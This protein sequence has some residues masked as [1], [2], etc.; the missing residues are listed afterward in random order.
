MPPFVTRR[1]FVPSVEQ[2]TSIEQIAI[3]DQAPTTPA[4]GVGT[5]AI[6]CVGEYEDGPFAMPREVFGEDDLAS[7]FGGF[8]YTYGSLVHQNPS[9]RRRAQELWNGNA[10][11]KLK[12]LRPRRLMVTRVDTSVGNLIGGLRATVRSAPGP[13]R[14]DTTDQLDVSFD[15]GGAVSLP[16]LAAGVA[17]LN[18]SGASFP[19]ALAGQI[20]GVRID[21]GAEVN[22]QLPIGSTSLADVITTFNNALGYTAASDN[23]G[24]LRISGIQQGTGGR[25]VLRQVFGNSLVALGFTID[26]AGESSASG[27]GDVADI[28][29]VTATEA[30]AAWS[31]TILGAGGISV[32]TDDGRLAIGS[33]T[34]I[35]VSAGNFQ[36]VMGFGTDQATRAAQT[37]FSIPAGTRVTA[38]SIDFVT[39]QTVN[40]PVGGGTDALIL[41]V[42]HAFDDGSG[43]AVA[44]NTTATFVDQPLQ[45]LLGAVDANGLTAALTE[46]QMDARYEAAFDSTLD[47]NSVARDANFTLSARRTAA[48]MRAGRSNAIR[49]SENGLRGRVFHGRASFGISPSDAITDVNLYRSDRVFYTYPGWQSQISEI[50]T[51]GNTGGLGFNDS[52]T[53][54]IGG[55][56]P[57]AYINSV[58]NPEENPGQQTG[59]LTFVQ[60]LEPIPSFQAATTSLEGPIALY[61]Q[62]KSAGI[63]APRFGRDGQAAYQS[64]VTTSLEPGRTTQKRRKMADFIQDSLA[65]LMIPF[66]K[67]LATDAREA[68]ITATINS[69]LVILL[70]DNFPENQRIA[71]FGV[72]N[73]NASNPDYGRLGISARKVQVQILNSLD[74]ILLVTEIGEG[75]V[76]V[77]DAAAAA[78]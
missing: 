30:N 78:A 14:L 39:M 16:V 3:V 46:P 34:T 63:C 12:N 70:S 35:Q 47:I 21:N 1:T 51:V 31:G 37:A 64:E 41:P 76:V 22:V 11:L 45:I 73:I 33:T 8:G 49:A 36:Q 53:I 44:A 58:L 52:G 65:N 77:N 23:G 5:G 19:V 9:A 7:Q 61:T 32:V 40:I 20:V 15:G 2:L 26:G 4:T 48:T 6:L 57:L 68:A 50:A 62:F 10:Y 18:G 29:A 25:V 13:W 66:S 75:V 60:A 54:T 55:D 74:T 59:L 43:A 27:T 17:Q 72:R 71:A 28:D 67:K 42:R 38:N 69:F 56:G 24:Q